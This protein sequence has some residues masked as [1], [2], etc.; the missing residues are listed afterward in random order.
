MHTSPTKIEVFDTGGEI[1]M[2]QKSSIPVIR[3]IAI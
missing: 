1:G 2:A 3:T